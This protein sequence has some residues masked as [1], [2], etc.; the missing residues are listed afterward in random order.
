[1]QV[2]EMR[3]TPI[4]R[5]SRLC[6]GSWITTST[7]TPY[8]LVLHTVDDDVASSKAAVADNLG[9]IEVTIRTVDHY[10]EKEQ[11]YSVGQISRIGPLHEKSKKAG[12]HAVSG[13]SSL[14]LQALL[15]MADICAASESPGLSPQ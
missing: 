9:L 14:R 15:L 12:V 5:V 13:V 8:R 7:R 3:N 11:Y 2:L 6:S 4:T 10:L 1:M